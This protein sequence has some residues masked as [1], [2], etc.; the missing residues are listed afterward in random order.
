PRLP[1]SRGWT[2]QRSLISS[3][4]VDSAKSD[5]TTTLTTDRCFLLH[6]CGNPVTR[7][8]PEPVVTQKLVLV[9]HMRQ[10]AP[11][12]V[13]ADQAHQTAVGVPPSRID[14]VQQF[15]HAT[16][17]LLKPLHHRRHPLALP[18]GR[19]STS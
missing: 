7:N 8:R 4:H 13:P 10:D 16:A 3:A 17:P 1:K 6:Y 15:R 2:A 11:Q 14:V 12:A 18:S 5:Q 19:R 9:Q